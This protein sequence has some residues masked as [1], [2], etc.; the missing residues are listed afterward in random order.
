MDWG[1]R[2]R[3]KE[4]TRAKYQRDQLIEPLTDWMLAFRGG[5]QKGGF[6]ENI[7]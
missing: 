7:R 6:N 5:L 2:E 4:V 3:H 1:H